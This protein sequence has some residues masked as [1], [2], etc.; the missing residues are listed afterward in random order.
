[1]YIKLTNNCYL[2]LKYHIHNQR[3]Q[4]VKSK[5]IDGKFIKK[6]IPL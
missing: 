6:Y 4:Q 5:K 1:M 3:L 2:V